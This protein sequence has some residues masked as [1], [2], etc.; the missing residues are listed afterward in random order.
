MASSKKYLIFSLFNFLHGLFELEC[1]QNCCKCYGNYVS[2]RF[3]HINTFCLIGNNMRHNVNQ[4][5]QQNKFPHY[6]NDDRVN[7][8]SERSKGHL[9]GNLNAEQTDSAEIY[10]QHRC[11]KVYQCFIRCKNAYKDLREK[12]NRCPQCCGVDHTGH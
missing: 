3:C 8:F 12:H 5:E 4:W 9:T 11:C 10:L 1:K 6:R 7:R 2:N